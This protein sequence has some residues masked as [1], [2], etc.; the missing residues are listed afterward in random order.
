[1]P[2][3][4]VKILLVD[5]M[6]SLRMVIRM[7]LVRLG[8]SDIDEAEDGKSAQCMIEFAMESGTPYSVII[9]DWDMPEMSGIELLEAVRSDPTLRNIPFLMVTGDS[10]QASA[11]R[12]F[13][14]GVTDYLVKPISP[15]SLAKKVEHVLKLSREG[16]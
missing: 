4:P 5:D 13:S 8:Y 2:Q 7:E 14:A 3:E 15:D 10:E 12:A 16:K 6:G 9:C 1:M 11:Q